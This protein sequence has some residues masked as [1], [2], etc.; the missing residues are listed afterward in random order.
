MRELS[1]YS[2]S[3]WLAFSPV[4][5]RFKYL[6]NRALE[7][8]Y[9]SCGGATRDRFLAEN[10]PG[11]GPTLAVTIAFNTPWVVDLF[12]RLARL[13]LPAASVI[14]ADN[15]SRARTQAEISAAPSRP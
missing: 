8:V 1:Y 4:V 5:H 3:E 15:S 9:R 6:R 2:A 7:R 12:L 11:L 13:N 10:A 14:V